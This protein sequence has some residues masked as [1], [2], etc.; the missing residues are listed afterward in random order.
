MPWELAKSVTGRRY[1]PVLPLPLAGSTTGSQELRRYICFTHPTIEGERMLS[2][3]QMLWEPE[4]SQ[5][6]NQALPTRPGRCLE[7]PHGPSARSTTL[8][9]PTRFAQSP[10]VK[11]QHSVQVLP[12]SVL[13]SLRPE[14]PSAR[15]TSALHLQP[16]AHYLVQL[17][18]KHLLNDLM[19]TLTY[20]YFN[21][22]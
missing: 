7:L 8:R 1:S 3:L 4:C 10:H 2:L 17:G 13:F 21:H 20:M 6:A 5:G 9:L 22:E 12:L 16:P 14:A 15:G 18:R 19:L 11:L